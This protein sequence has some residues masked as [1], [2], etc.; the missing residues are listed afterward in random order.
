MVSLGSGGQLVIE[1]TN[2]YLV[3]SGDASPDLYVFEVGDPEDVLVEISSDGN[4]W[5]SVGGTLAANGLIDI[6]QFGFNV[7]ERFYFVRLTDNPRQGAISGISVGADIDAV[8]AIRSSVNE[9]YTAGGT[10]ISVSSN[11]SPTLLNNVIANSITGINIDA[12][13]DTSVV[14]GTL[15]YRNDQNTGGVATVGEFAIEAQDSQSVFVDPVRSVLYPAPLSPSIDSSVDSLADRNAL[16]SVKQVLGL[17]ASPI[18]APDF[19]VNGVLRVDD[20]D[21]DTPS[22]LGGNVFKDRGAIDRADRVGPSQ[23][24]ISPLDNDSLGADS[25]PEDGIVELVNVS[26]NYFD[27][28]LV[29]G[30]GENGLAQG[31]GINDATVTSNA[32]MVYRNE[33]PL[34][35]GIDYRFGYNSTSNTI[36]LT[37]LAGVWARDAVYRIEMLGT[38]EASVSTLRAEDY[39]DGSQISI[40]GEDGQTYVFEVD[41]GYLI[42]IPQ[43]ISETEN[44]E[45]HNVADGEQFLIDDGVRQ[46]LFEFD[47]NNDVNF[48]AVAIQIAENDT[49]QAVAQKTAAAVG[50]VGLRLTATGFEDGRVQIL[51]SRLLELQSASVNLGITGQAGVS[52]AYGIRVPVE[53]GRVTELVDGDQ[54][55]IRLGNQGARTFEFD[56]NNDVSE[57]AVRVAMPASGIVNAFSDAIVTAIATAGLGLTPVHTGEGFIAIG[58]DRRTTIDVGATALTVVGTPGS[59][60]SIPV[61]LNLATTSSANDVAEAMASAI[62]AAGIPG[63]TVTVLGSRLFIE[64]AEGVTGSGAEIVAPISDYAGNPILPNQ[65]DGTSSVEIFIG[66][67]LDYGDAPDSPYRSRLTNNGPRHTVVDGFSLG[68]TV[69]ADPDARLDNR[70]ED[71]GV[72]FV[73]D[74]FAAFETNITVSAQ[75]I[76]AGRGG[77]LSAWIDADGDGVFE[78]TEAIV[79]GRSLVN[80]DND[81]P[82]FRIPSFAD[83]GEVYARFRYSSTPLDS[84]MGEAPD[85]EVEDYAVQILANPYQNQADNLDVTGDGSVAPI[86]VLRVIHFLNRFGTTRLSV[87]VDQNIIDT[88]G[89]LDVDGNGI[90]NPTDALLVINFINKR[91]SAG[92]GSGEGE[93]EGEGYDAAGWIPAGGTNGNLGYGISDNRTS[94]FDTEMEGDA[95]RSSQPSKESERWVDS[96]DSVL[97]DPASQAVEYVL[98]SII[99]SDGKQTRDTNDSIFEDDFWT[100]LG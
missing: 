7:A 78:D 56:N 98:D 2:N 99:E 1:F 16:V 81:L 84:P 94:R 28:R 96:Q 14:G 65:T 58:G 8:G 42:R 27:I 38:R 73:G 41:L 26:L 3:P 32:V 62:R 17:P 40:F 49:I 71:D 29:D 61:T 90:V 10:G 93:G 22:G 80:G 74:L 60:A 34:V 21:V 48:G 39:E 63:V 25:N 67:G 46:V 70:D 43:T 20:P 57:G 66:Q 85:G 72:T 97:N 59:P 35:E 95:N 52:P 86:D 100:E 36:R 91:G 33:E 30:A 89:R 64:G 75:G 44:T 83:V 50:S 55:T 79:I 47:T 4:R 37:P 24:V 12:S 6:D 54:F 15:F 82:A 69:T 76:E 77:F 5:T 9:V 18:L 51:G 45:I 88:Y 13:S 11:A 68:T 31:S 23:V 19:D 87:P 53:S 92:S